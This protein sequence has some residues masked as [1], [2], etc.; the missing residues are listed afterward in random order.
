MITNPTDKQLLELIEKRF[1]VNP[2]FEGKL[3]DYLNLRELEGIAY[4]EMIHD[5]S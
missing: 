4:Q 3:T 5:A 1:E 2:S